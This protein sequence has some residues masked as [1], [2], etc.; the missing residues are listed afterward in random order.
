MQGYFQITNVT[1][2]NNAAL[3]TKQLDILDLGLAL[4]KHACLSSVERLCL[5]PL[6]G[7]Q[8]ALMNPNAGSGKTTSQYDYTALGARAQISADIGLGGRYEHVLSVML[9]VNA[10]SKALAAP[11]DCTLGLD[12]CAMVVGLDRGGPAGYFGLGYT[13]RFNTPFGQSPFVTLE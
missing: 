2:G 4:F 9:G 3:R 5:T 13:Y 10:Y 8:L 12:A 11:S 7:V 1:E 6:L